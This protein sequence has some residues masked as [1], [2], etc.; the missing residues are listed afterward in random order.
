MLIPLYGFLEGDT[1]GLLILAHDDWT[2]KEMADT[3]VEMASVRVCPPPACH[4]VIDG[5]S[6][7]DRRTVAEVG[8]APLDRVDVRRGRDR[9]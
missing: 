1:I 7:D 2:M 4:V 3:L 9:P 5:R 8:L 6:V